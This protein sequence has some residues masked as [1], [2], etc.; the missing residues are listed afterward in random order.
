[1][2]IDE[3]QEHNT[4]PILISF[5]IAV[6]VAAI[7]WQ[8]F[9]NETEPASVTPIAAVIE[10]V[11][12]IAEEALPLNELPA[13]TDIEQ[14]PE[15]ELIEP[16]VFVA[17]L[18]MLN[19]SD[20]LVQTKLAHLTWRKELLKLVINDDMIRRFVV[21]TENFTR[22]LVAYEHSPLA[23]P[24]AGFNAL[25]TGKVD[26]E[27]RELWQWDEKSTR[28][29]SL[30]V[31]LLR[32]FDSESLVQ[33]YIELKPLINQ[34]YAELGYPEQDF[35]EVLQQAITRVLDMEIPK[36]SLDIVRPSVMFQFQ[37]KNIEALSETEK[38]MLRLGKENLLV[39]K[40]VLLEISEKLSRAENG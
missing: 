3:P 13:Q 31:D 29:F 2:A 20:N 38:L 11:E 23:L 18:P 8:Y 19:D 36:Q 32:S 7:V 35:S 4:S 17:P 1:M 39:V 34:A 33:W 26:P 40:S 22:G 15:T 9:F 14:A 6:I 24:S 10:P 21:F 25:D 27:Q 12:L 30:Y 5:I 37:D 28:R 16:D